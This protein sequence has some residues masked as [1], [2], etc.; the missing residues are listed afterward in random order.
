MH[1][2]HWLERATGFSKL[3]FPSITM[4]LSGEQLAFTKFDP[5]IGK[6]VEFLSFLE[7]VRVTFRHE[8]DE[9]SLNGHRAA[10]T[11]IIPVR[12]LPFPAAYLCTTG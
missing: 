9:I 1:G 11:V 6:G 8:A 4:S 10:C 5:E 12:C 7:A 3:I 2:T